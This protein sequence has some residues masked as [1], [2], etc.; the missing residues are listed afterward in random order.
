MFLKKVLRLPRTLA[1]RLTLWYAGVFT[2][3]SIVAFSVFYLL[4][5]SVIQENRDQDLLE[6]V[7]E[8]SSLFTSKGI[9]EVKSEILV[10]AESDGVEKIFFRLLSLNGEELASTNMSSWAS[11]SINKTA[12]KRLAHGANNVFETLA[13]PEQEHKARIIYGII[14][15]DLILQIGES[16]EEDEQ[17]LEIIRETFGTIMAFVI[18]FSALIGWLMAKRALLGVE[19]VTITALN[20]SKGDFEQ[21][22]PPKAR[23]DEIERLATTFNYMLDRINALITGIRDMTDNIAHDLR[24]PIGRI[25]GIAEATLISDSSIMEYK[26]TAVSIIEEC[27]LLL[28]MVNTMLDISEAETGASKLKKD[29]IDIADEVRKACELFRPIADNT[30]VTLITTKIPGSFY[31]YGDRQKVQRMVANL[32]DNALK[33]TPSGGAVTVSVIS[34]D[35][36]IAIAFSDTGIGIPEVDLPHIFNRFYRCD[37]SRSRAG[38]GLGLSL[39]KAVAQAHGGEITVTSC[40]EKGSTFRIILP[41]SPRPH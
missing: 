22:V 5:T 21:R 17:F 19:E 8:F 36:K 37:Q 2:I 25:R 14:G 30:G 20:I 15:P 24:S 12:V 11:A 13:V 10:E 1:L 18:L 31:V 28:D 32:L 27:D 26:N 34:D 3:S 9:K 33:Y 7:E 6:D 29:E 41:R 38:V 39:A 4:I 35:E 40:P 23:G 16:L